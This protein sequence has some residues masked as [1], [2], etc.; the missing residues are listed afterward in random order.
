MEGNNLHVHLH[1]FPTQA[2]LKSELGNQDKDR[3]WL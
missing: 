2:A 1:S 3:A